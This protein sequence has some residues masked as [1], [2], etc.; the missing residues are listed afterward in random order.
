M[1]TRT[2]FFQTREF[3]LCLS[4]D[5]KGED[6]NEGKSKKEIELFPDEETPYKDT[7]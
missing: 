5:G 1:G 4:V 3:C 6:E 2:L 7:L